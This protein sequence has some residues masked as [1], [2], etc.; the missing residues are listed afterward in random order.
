M[1]DLTY[2]Y[3]S[4][5]AKAVRD[6]HHHSLR[7]WLSNGIGLAIVLLEVVLYFTSSNLNM[8]WIALLVL[9]LLGALYVIMCYVQPNKFASDARY[10]KPFTLSADERTLRLKSDDLDNTVPWSDIRKICETS[11]YYFL[12]LDQTQFWIAPKETFSDR[13]QEERFRELA[14]RYLTINRGLIR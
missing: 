4:H 2:N 5:M 3:S 9:V 12:F 14:G 11:R 1:I 8:L 10:A 6:Y 13:E 7:F